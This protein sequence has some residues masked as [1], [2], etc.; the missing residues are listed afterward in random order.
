MMMM[1]DYFILV[2]TKCVKFLAH[3][4]YA[5]Q[6]KVS[7]LNTGFSIWN[8]LMR[9]RMLFLLEALKTFVEM[10]VSSYRVTS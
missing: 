3:V 2:K 9:K 10:I 8:Y 6:M 4:H 5:L 1:I 7:A